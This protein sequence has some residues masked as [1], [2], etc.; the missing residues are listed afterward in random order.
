MKKT[1]TQRQ[2][3]MEGES[4]VKMKAESRASTSRGTSQMGG[5]PPEA[6]RQ[7]WNRLSLTGPQNELTL[8]TP[9]SQTSSV[10]RYERMNFCGWSP[11]PPIC[12]TL[13]GKL[14][15]MERTAPLRLCLHPTALA[16]PTLCGPIPRTLF[17]SSDHHP[18]ASVVVWPP[19]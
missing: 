19:V 11:L 8:K 6:G 4:H 18:F 13:L 9:Y 14:G 2:T 16:H 10:Q 12:G 3:L 15:G 5:H 1:W 17:S 7:A